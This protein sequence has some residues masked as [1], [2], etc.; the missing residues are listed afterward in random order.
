MLL[1]ARLTTVVVLAGAILVAGCASTR[2]TADPGALPTGAP[3]QVTASLKAIA[4]APGPV[5]AASLWVSDAPDRKF[6]YTLNGETHDVIRR[7]EKDSRGLVTVAWV[8]AASGTLR[9]SQVVVEGADGALVSPQST[10]IDRGVISRFR[11]VLTILDGSMATGDP[12]TQKKVDV[13][14]ADADRPGRI[15]HR[16]S[17]TNT[18]EF[19]GES[20]IE[21]AGRTITCAV[22]R[23]TF[24]ATFGP[25]VV[26]RVSHQWLEPGAGLI[27]EYAHEE[28]R[29]FG[30]QTEDRHESWIA[31]E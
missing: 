18:V 30:I 22:I 10:N 25:A 2:P 14:V 15:K 12:S 1:T 26:H 31:A 5:R 23:A 7:I 29:T 11:P 9:S 8:D 24:D 16:G 3:P 19:M 4:K 28:V 17:A 6:T 20:S 21:A 13:L 27:A